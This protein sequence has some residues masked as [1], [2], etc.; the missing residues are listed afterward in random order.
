MTSTIALASVTLL[1]PAGAA[2][3]AAAIPWLR[4]RGTPA[5]ALCILAS[6]ASFVAAALLLVDRLGGAEPGRGASPGFAPAAPSSPKS[7]STSTASRAR[8]SRS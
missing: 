3:L 2:L 5:A 4:K 1:A 8:C 6:V 7:A